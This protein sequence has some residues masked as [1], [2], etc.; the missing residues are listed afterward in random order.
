MNI[1][2]YIFKSKKQRENETAEPV[3]KTEVPNAYS[4]R[5]PFTKSGDI[6]SVRW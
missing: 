4:G 5:Y 6:R 3:V 2:D 1:L